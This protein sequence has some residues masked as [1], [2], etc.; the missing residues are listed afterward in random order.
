MADDE[1]TLP[2]VYPNKN[3]SL[4]DY[5]LDRLREIKRNRDEEESKHSN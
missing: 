4:E 5:V 3:Q 1:V 2:N